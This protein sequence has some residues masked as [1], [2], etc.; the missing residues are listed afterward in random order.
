[1]GIGIVFSRRVTVRRRSRIRGTGASLRLWALVF[2][3]VL[4]GANLMQ[5]CPPSSPAVLA[6]AEAPGAGYGSHAGRS[7]RGARAHRPDRADHSQHH[8]PAGRGVGR[9]TAMDVA[10]HPSVQSCCPQPCTGCP[11][12]SCRDFVAAHFVAVL[13]CDNIAFLRDPGEQPGARSPLVRDYPLDPP[14][15]PPPRPA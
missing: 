11:C 14:P 13:M 10:W 4:F 5:V 12:D 6:H 8:G 3:V 2:G 1:M 15:S 9:N 7:V